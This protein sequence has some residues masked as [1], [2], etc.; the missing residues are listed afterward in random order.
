MIHGASERTIDGILRLKGRW[1]GSHR[2]MDRQNW[3]R[4]NWTR[5]CFFTVKRQNILVRFLR[6]KVLHERGKLT[7]PHSHVICEK[8][9]L[10]IV[11]KIISTVITFIRIL[12]KRRTQK[13]FYRF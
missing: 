9:V 10:N 13:L 6:E 11:Q 12:S 2:L 1:L 5:V 4:N 8:P 3:W 7:L